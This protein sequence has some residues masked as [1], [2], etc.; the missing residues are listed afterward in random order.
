MNPD[1]QPLLPL[2]SSSDSSSSA[3]SCKSVL[4]LACGSV[5]K[6]HNCPHNAKI[7]RKTSSVQP[8][9]VVHAFHVAPQAVQDTAFVEL[10]RLLTQ[11][12]QMSA[13]LA[14]EASAK[15]T[16]SATMNEL[17]QAKKDAAAAK[18][19]ADVVKRREAAA[20]A[21]TLKHKATISKD[22][23]L[24][25]KT[26]S[27]GTSKIAP[28]VSAFETFTIDCHAAYTRK[29]MDAKLKFPPAPPPAPAPPPSA[30]A[31]AGAPPMITLIVQLNQNQQY[32]TERLISCHASG[33]VVLAWHFESSVPPAPHAPVWQ[34]ITDAHIVGELDK[35]GMG[36]YDTSGKCLS[37]TPTP[38]A[39]V[40]YTNNTH[41]YEVKVV[42]RPAPL[43]PSASSPV[44]PA[45]FP[46]LYEE[47]HKEMLF[48]G[49][50]FFRLPSA[51]IEKLLK[52]TDFDQPNTVVKNSQVIA[53][54]ATLVS[55][56]GQAFT[57]DVSRCELWLKPVWFKNWLA[58][59]KSRHLSHARLL[60]HGMK[61]QAYDLLA[62]DHSG[63][64]MGFSSPAMRFG[65]AMYGSVSD[66]IASFYNAMDGKTK[67]PDG[68][69]VLGLLWT[70]PNIR[71]GAYEFYNLHCTRF[72]HGYCP[73]TVPNAYAVRD[74]LLW[75]PLGLAVANAEGP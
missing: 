55:S 27:V 11:H 71:A 3:A 9:A 22:K 47:W 29:M 62:K 65:T 5:S 58:T 60:M 44:V 15:A 45:V 30:P 66:H 37:F 52:S 10:Q 41:T 28:L 59:A 14:T 57:Y 51:Q 34:Q 69:F 1:D 64:D 16:L 48:N 6:P 8:C 4:C 26:A 21:D 43:A 31:P 40:N 61:S 18:E 7:M 46:P 12:G 72:P 32:N 70:H 42:S 38:G 67:Y 74:Q 73:S 23:S 49:D 20:K 17:R 35:L 63:F 13:A 33:G 50:T 54:L 36:T 39:T 24:K 68:T 53:N 75:L 19:S 56:A 25:K 2:P